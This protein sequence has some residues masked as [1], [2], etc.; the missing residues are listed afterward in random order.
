MRNFIK[1]LPVDYC[2]LLQENFETKTKFDESNYIMFRNLPVVTKNLTKFKRYVNRQVTYEDISRFTDYKEIEGVLNE[3][4]AVDEIK[5]QLAKFGPVDDAELIDFNK[6][7]IT[8]IVSRATSKPTKDEMVTFEKMMQEALTD[9]KVK[10]DVDDF[11]NVLRTHRHDFIRMMNYSVKT[12]N[13]DIAKGYLD[14]THQEKEE[15]AASILRKGKHLKNLNKGI[16]VHGFLKFNDYESKLKFLLSP[17]YQFGMKFY[18]QQKSVYFYDADFGNTLTIHSKEFENKSLNHCWN[19][20]NSVLLNSGF[21]N[22]DL[23]IVGDLKSL[24]DFKL[25]DI[26]VRPNA[27]VSIRFHSFYEAKEA[28]YYLSQSR[29]SGMKRFKIR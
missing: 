7:D 16:F 9:E 23:W 5:H 19:I 29:M 8:E 1:Y 24:K 14:L 12:S 11:E 15:I 13:K 18:D 27:S 6:D 26:L 28:F 21:T 3:Q 20:V 4:L 25:E 22:D 17:A 2:V 10:E